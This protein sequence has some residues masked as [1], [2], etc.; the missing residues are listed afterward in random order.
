MVPLPR[1]LLTVLPFI[2]TLGL[3]VQSGFGCFE[4]STLAGFGTLSGK[5]TGNRSVGSY[6]R[7]FI[8]GITRWAKLAYTRGASICDEGESTMSTGA[9]HRIRGV[10]T[11]GLALRRSITANGL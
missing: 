4:H 3:Y 1:W 2:H 7:P 11:I 5:S 9:L 6:V 10:L 8:C